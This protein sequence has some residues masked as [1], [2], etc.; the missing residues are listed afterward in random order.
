MSLNGGVLT[1]CEKEGFR[2]IRAMLVP[3]FFCRARFF[4]FF[5]VCVC[6]CVVR[7]AKQRHLKT[8]RPHEFHFFGRLLSVHV[9]KCDIRFRECETL[10]PK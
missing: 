6:V 5:C 1:T 3:F 8:H 2:G 4:F 10:G 9:R 7:N